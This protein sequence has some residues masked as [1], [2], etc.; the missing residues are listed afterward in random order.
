MNEVKVHIY[1]IEHKLLNLHHICEKK[2][3]DQQNSQRILTEA[4]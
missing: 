3:I 2:N 4:A 1:N